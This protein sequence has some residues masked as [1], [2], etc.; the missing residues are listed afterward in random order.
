VSKSGPRRTQESPDIPSDDSAFDQTVPPPTFPPGRG[1]PPPDAMN[2]QTAIQETSEL[3]GEYPA[4]LNRLGPG[5][6]ASVPT[7]ASLGRKPVCSAAELSAFLHRYRAEILSPLELPTILRAAELARLNQGRE[8]I[9]LD[10]SLT[11]EPGLRDFAEASRRVGRSHLRRLRPLQDQRALQKFLAASDENRVLPW[12][13]VVY[14]I[15]LGIYAV[16]FRQG[17]VHYVERTLAGWVDAVK[18]GRNLPEGDCERIL[19]EFLPE[20]PAFVERALGAQ[21]RALQIC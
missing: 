1:P 5:A 19:G 11:K 15:T 10:R 2:A 14:G 8:L 4:L 13:T 16:P 12:H 9:E 3:L 20:T 6:D 18:G 21:P 17:L 7:P